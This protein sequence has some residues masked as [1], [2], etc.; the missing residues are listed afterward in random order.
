K[1]QHVNF[2]NSPYT[3]LFRSVSLAAYP[4]AFGDVI[5]AARAVNVH[6]NTLRYRLRRL[7]EISG[8]NLDDP[9]E[10]LVAA[11]QL[12]TAPLDENTARSEEHT[13]ELQSREN[14][15]CR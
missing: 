7:G 15:V 11:I 9:D 4:D 3:T 5:K 2:I 1:R 6:P 10:R 8:L 14:I 13:S 12:R